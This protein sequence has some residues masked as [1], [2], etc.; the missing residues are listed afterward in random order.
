MQILILLFLFVFSAIANTPSELSQLARERAPQIKIY[1]EGANV[2]KGLLKQSH[3]LANPIFTYQGGRLKSATQTGQVTDLTLM[4]PIPWPGKRAASIRSNEFLARISEMDVS[5]SKLFLAHRV[6]LLA[7]S[8]AVN[9]EIEK[10]NKER[11][12]RFKIISKYLATRPLASPKQILDRDLIE[13][14]IRLLEKVMYELSARKNGLKE[15]LRLLTGVS[16]FEVKI[17]WEKLPGPHDRDFYYSNLGE[18]WR[19]KKVNQS[20]QLSEN[21]VEEARLQARPDILIGVNYRQE[22]VAP[23]NH[24]YHGQ[25]AVVIPIVDRGQHSVQIA[26]AQVRK[27]QA[28]MQLTVQETNTE[29]GYAYED[30]K[31]AENALSIFPLN[32][33]KK[34]EDRFFKAEDAFRKGQIDALTFLQ[35]DTQVHESISL[36]Y[37][38]RLEYLMSLSRVEQLIGHYLEEK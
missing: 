37:S 16:D 25:V 2:G 38:S 10:H 22:N 3:L 26:R 31:A 13:S 8:L 23:V 35:S 21:R 19:I 32:L 7:Y 14:Q 17:D 20:V 6:Y 33:R 34:S 11:R 28:S 29:F 15:E 9:T 12:D 5:E 27:E 4:Q 30:L 36:V 1:L 18:G 24:F